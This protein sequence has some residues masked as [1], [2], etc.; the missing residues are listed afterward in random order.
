[1]TRLRDLDLARHLGDAS[2]KQQFVTPMF[3]LIAPRYDRF[4]RV[5]S[6]GMDA[7]WKRVLMEWVAESF[8]SR[9]PARAL[10]LACGTG[11]LALETQRRFPAVEAHGVD[12]SPQMIALAR[13]R[14]HARL[15]EFAVGDMM[16]LEAATA[17]VDLVTAGYGFRNTPDFRR[18]LLE[19]ARVTRA[20]G[21]LATLDFYRP[22]STIWRALF[23][24]YLR[25]AGNIVGWMWH[26]EPVAYGYIGPSIAGFVSA[27]EFSAALRA[28]GFVPLRQRRFLL[29]GV[30]L[31]LA[32]RV[33]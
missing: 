23:L 7:R 9:S 28:A 32:R 6:F 30:A 4:T 24:W 31:H 29:G 8:G 17:S 16:A 27:E 12:A 2:L 1:M 3:D 13:Q 25:T 33:V 15:P 11:D 5:F 22:R 10:D 26:R 18:A 19:A 20:G 21:L 14:D